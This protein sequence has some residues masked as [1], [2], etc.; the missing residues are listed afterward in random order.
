MKIPAPRIQPELQTHR[1]ILHL[2]C[3]SSV[4]LGSSCRDKGFSTA[5][6]GIAPNS[7][8]MLRMSPGDLWKPVSRQGLS[9]GS[10][11]TRLRWAV[12]CACNGGSAATGILQ[13]CHS[14]P[15]AGSCAEIWQPLSTAEPSTRLAGK[16]QC[17]SQAKELLSHLQGGINVVWRRGKERNPGVKWL[18]KIWAVG[19]LG[20]LPHWALLSLC[21]HWFIGKGIFPASGKQKPGFSS[22]CLQPARQRSGLRFPYI[23][24]QGKIQHNN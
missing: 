19:A 24:Y 12:P 21:E 8:M 2:V 15:R 3:S 9:F 4:G 17:L 18:D 1:S 6:M 14:H 10:C 5:G 16:Q 13:P 23:S 11:L 22:V 7:K 20:S